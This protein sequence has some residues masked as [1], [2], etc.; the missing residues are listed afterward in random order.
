MF[1]SDQSPF[2]KAIKNHHKNVVLFMLHQKQRSIA[3]FA[4]Q[5]SIAGFAIQRSIAIFNCR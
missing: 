5:R 1:S 3:D 4:K 2:S